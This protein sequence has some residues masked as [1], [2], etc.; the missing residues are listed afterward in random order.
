MQTVVKAFFQL[1][2]L[3]R[4]LSLAP[5]SEWT[6]LRATY[7]GLWCLWGRP[8]V[9]LVALSPGSGYWP[10]CRPFLTPGRLPQGI[11]LRLDP[12]GPLC[13]SSIDCVCPVWSRY[14]WLPGLLG[15]S[16]AAPR[17]LPL[18]WDLLHQRPFHGFAPISGH[19][20]Y[21]RGGCPPFLLH[22]GYFPLYGV[23][24]GGCAPSLVHYDFP[25]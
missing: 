1:L 22:G 23:V 2:P 6:L 9:G 15:F 17:L 12:N 11:P 8:L 20:G 13:L 18:R 5:L 25:M 16:V 19:L 21:L 14:E 3:L 24:T 4:G 10:L 7:R